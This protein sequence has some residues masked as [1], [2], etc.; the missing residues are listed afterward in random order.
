M[1]RLISASRFSSCAWIRRNLGLI[2]IR[3]TVLVGALVGI[4]AG[5]AVCTKYLRQEMTAVM[6]WS[7]SKIIRIE[8]GAV[9]ISTNDLTALLRLYKVSDQQ[10]IKDLVSLARIARQ[11]SWW[12]RY[13]ETLP[14]TFFTYIEYE[15]SASAIRQYEPIL[16]PGLLQTRKYAEVVISRYRKRLSV[17]EVTARVELRM[18]RQQLLAQAPLPAL[19]FVVDEAAIL[20]LAGES[21]LREEQLAHLISVANRPNVTVEI[22]PFSTGLHSGI[23]EN[24]TILEFDN[25]SDSDVLYFEGARDFIFSRDDAE[26]ISIYREMFEGLRRASLGPAGSLGF[27][28]KIAGDNA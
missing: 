28:K 12:S 5:A 27:L 18:E 25:E 14:P 8:T 22:I 3:M 11:P 6:D 13:R 2:S 17:E 26:E 24:V 21:E 7:L 10:R 1:T 20:R 23:A 4:L 16:V 9:G 15:A 19:Y